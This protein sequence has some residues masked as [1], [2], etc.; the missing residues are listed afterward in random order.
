MR[1]PRL[2][3]H[4]KLETGEPKMGRNGVVVIGSHVHG[5]IM[6]VSRFP[7]AD[8]T[9]LGWDYEEGVDGGKGSHQAIACARLGLPTHFVEE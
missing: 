5:L 7:S 1:R 3:H 6:R 8:E 4:W 2:V 9:V